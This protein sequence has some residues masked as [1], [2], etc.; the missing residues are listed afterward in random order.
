GIDS[1]MSPDP[2]KDTSAVSNPGNPEAPSAPSASPNETTDEPLGITSDALITPDVCSV[3]LNFCNGAGSTGTD[4][5]E[6]GCALSTAISKCI[7]LV[8]GAGCTVQC[9][10][11]MRT[12]SGVKTWRVQCGNTC[13]AEGQNCSAKFQCCTPGTVGCP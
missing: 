7:S 1:P 6:S 13:C 5:T 8:H 9:N 12:P 4:C 3:R 11:I 2:S 10:A